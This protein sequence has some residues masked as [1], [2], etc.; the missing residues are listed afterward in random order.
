M[1]E[2]LEEKRKTPFDCGILPSTGF[3]S[4]R[5]QVL[6]YDIQQVAHLEGL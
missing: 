5:L 6:L 2:K 4:V 1:K 3:A